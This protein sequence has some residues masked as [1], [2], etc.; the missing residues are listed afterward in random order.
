MKWQTM[1]I[2]EIHNTNS[3]SGHRRYLPTLL[4][5]I[6]G[7]SLSIAIFAALYGRE[8]RNIETDFREVCHNRVEGFKRNIEMKLIS[9][10]S[11]QHFYMGSK[12]VERDE[13]EDFAGVFTDI[14][15][16][17]AL[18]WAPRVT[19]D[20]RDQFEKTVRAEGFDGFQITQR[21]NDGNLVRAGERTEYFP[22]L[23]VEPEAGNEEAFGFDLASEA[24]RKEA[25]DIC[26]G[27]DE[28]VATARIRLVREDGQQYAFLALMPVY[29]KSSNLNA[30]TDMMPEV[31]GLVLGVFR[32]G[33]L[34]EEI[35]STF[36]PRGIDIRIN[37]LTH[38]DRHQELY[39]H[40]SR[41]SKEKQASQVTGADQ[42]RKKICDYSEFIVVGGRKWSIDFNIVNG[43]ISSYKTW[44]S[45]G[46]LIIGCVLSISLAG[47]LFVLGGRTAV[48]ESKVRDRT[49][50]LNEE[51][52]QRKRIEAELKRHTAILEATSDLVSTSTPDEKVTYMNRA[53]AE[54]LGLAEGVSGKQIPD[55]HPK[56]AFEIVEKE[57]IPIAI[58]DGIWTGE[59]AILA[60]D[61]TEIPVSQV[62]MSHKSES[63]E[64]EYLSTIMRDISESKEHQRYRERLM[65]TLEAKNKELQSVVYIASHDLKS[66]LV[67][68]HGFSGELEQNC[69]KL[70]QLLSMTDLDD[71]QKQRVKMILNEDIPEDI[72]FIKKGVEKMESL[73]KGLLRVSRVGSEAMRIERL[74][75][76]GM[77]DKI[78]DSMHFQISTNDVEVTVGEI[79][80]CMG[81][82][83]GVNQVFSNLV[84]NALKY[85]S[86]DRKG[87][88]D[89]SGAV[90]GDSVVYCVQDNGNGISEISLSKVFEI[91]HRL[92]PTGQQEGEGIGL[93]IVT[94]ILDRQDGKIWV[95]SEPGKGSK[96]F[97]S[98]PVA[99]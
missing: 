4:A 7:F 91:F 70:R 2:E 83:A 49:A 18:E 38:E 65:K 30:S 40:R 24:V 84:D 42:S 15:A 14:R 81:D 50:E 22:V 66:P 52:K 95:E 8:Q 99:K 86:P 92:D 28:L 45:W 23:F 68:V 77:I 19:S 98:L 72:G 51:L 35:I 87:Q 61:G 13:F 44:H 89:I 17:Q 39:Y 63:G 1:S 48:I 79:P 96:F 74:D 85:L 75:I 36:D 26:R 31:E 73:L 27:G 6:G 57:G 59:T 47:Y 25:I 53:G 67:N 46:V 94:R 5:L 62:I 32:V 97:V 78:L 71:K 33:D 56:W 37:D 29:R 88:I 20:Q 34:F 80:N 55:V 82:K 43:F 76:R 41:L 21:D 60:G 16:I 3:A 64:V 11:L 12:L 90:E 69:T 54:M 58:R 9:L 93:T 10:H